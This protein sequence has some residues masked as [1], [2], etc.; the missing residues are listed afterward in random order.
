MRMEVMAM[1][2]SLAAG[3]A[4]ITQRGRPHQSSHATAKRG[5]YAEDA[6]RRGVPREILFVL[7]RRNP[8]SNKSTT[9]MVPFLFPGQQNER[10]CSGEEGQERQATDEV[11]PLRQSHSK[12]STPT[13]ESADNANEADNTAT[14]C[15]S[16]KISIQSLEEAVKDLDIPG[17]PDELDLS[18]KEGQQLQAADEGDLRRQS[19]SK[20]SSSA[21]EPA[22]VAKKER[23]ST[24]S[25][26]GNK[27]LIQSVEEAV[28]DKVGRRPRTNSTDGEL[29]LPQRGLCDENAVLRTYQWDMDKL[30]RRQKAPP[31][32]GFV[33]LGNTC[34]LNATLQCL[35]YVPTLCQSVAALPASCYE[36]NGGGKPRGGQRITMLLRALLRRVHGI[37]AREK[38]GPWKTSPIAPKI[39]HKAVTSC[40]LQGGH[41]FRPGRQE[42]AHELLIHLLDAMHEGELF[43]AGE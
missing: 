43:S 20:K 6:T 3:R 38:E 22:D 18:G 41:R 13:I 30:L 39:L 7:P 16:E 35:V 19:K 2:H 25:C 36:A 17:K 12:E 1:N 11:D 9:E 34:F 24:P 8:S 15:S 5:K 31:P 27:I 21:K 26:N 32:R 10:D 37:E 14:N 28:K 23:N 29:N 4:G 33:N 40:R 42:D